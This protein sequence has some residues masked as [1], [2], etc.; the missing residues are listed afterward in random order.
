VLAEQDA[1]VVTSGIH[2]DVV[3]H[4]ERL[5]ARLRQAIGQLAG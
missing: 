4:D 3:R 2:D 5:Q 1:R